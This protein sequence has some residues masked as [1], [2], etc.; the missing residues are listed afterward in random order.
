MNPF[1]AN[2]VMRILVDDDPKQSARARAAVAAGGFVSKTVVLEAFWVPESVYG[3]KRELI[4]GALM[5]FAALPGIEIEDASGLG[6]AVR[7]TQAGPD[8]EDAYHFVGARQKTG[9]LTYDRQFIKRAA[10]PGLRPQ[11]RQP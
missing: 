11:V 8:F 10:A 2:I 1:D 6:Q 5:D 3:L 9:F 7:L 4:L